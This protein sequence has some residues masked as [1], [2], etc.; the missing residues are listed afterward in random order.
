MGLVCFRLR[1]GD[2]VTKETDALYRQLRLVFVSHTVLRKRFTI[3]VAMGT[4][5]HCRVM[6]KNC[7]MPLQTAWSFRNH[8]AASAYPYNTPHTSALAEKFSPPH[9]ID[10]FVGVLQ[11]VKFVVHNAALRG[12]CCW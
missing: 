5:E 4:C 6:W 7:E 1:E 2:A 10:G 8:S 9:F 12:Q 3:R 11:N